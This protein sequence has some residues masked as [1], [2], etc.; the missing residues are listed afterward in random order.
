MSS[1]IGEELRTRVAWRAK[2]RCEYCLIHEN[3]TYFGCEVDH[4]I[5]LKHDGPTDFDNLAYACLICNR[6]KGSDLGSIL[7][8]SGSIIRF[9]N[10]RIDVWQEHFCLEESNIRSLTEIGEV[11][12]R[13]FGF[14]APER[15]LERKALISAGRYVTP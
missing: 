11:T 4:I 7:F 6:R 13:I 5:S 14:N 2:H 12:V 15:I 3:D 1:P 9:F 10:P 8:S